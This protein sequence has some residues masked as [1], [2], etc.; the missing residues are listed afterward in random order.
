MKLGTSGFA[1]RHNPRAPLR[2]QAWGTLT[3]LLI[4]VLWMN[5][6]AFPQGSPDPLIALLAR[7]PHDEAVLERVVDWCTEQSS[8]ESFSQQLLQS[9]LPEFAQNR[10]L[11]HTVVGRLWDEAGRAGEA[12]REYEAAWAAGAR[13]PQT[14]LRMT[15]L[16]IDTGWGERAREIWANGS[17]D[18]SA[19]EVRIRFEIAILC[20]GPRAAGE[21]L[22]TQEELVPPAERARWAEAAA[23]YESA[24]RLF[25]RGGQVTAAVRCWARAG[26]LDQA[27]G[28]WG[29]STSPIDDDTALALARL[30]GDPSLLDA[31]LEERNDDA[32]LRLRQQ[33]NLAFGAAPRTDTEATPQPEV[34][35]PNPPELREPTATSTQSTPTQRESHARSVLSGNESDIAPLL[36]PG[37]P[38]L[39]VV[40][41]LLDVGRERLARLEWTRWQLAPHAPDKRTWLP[42]LRRRMPSWFPEVWSPEV[43]LRLAER[44]RVDALP[45]GLIKDLERALV[46]AT[47]GSALEAQLLFHRGRLTDFDADL[48]RALR[49]APHA[50]IGSSGELRWVVPL[51]EAVKRVRGEL[52][53]LWPGEIRIPDPIDAPLGVAFGRPLHLGS[54]PLGVTEHRTFRWYLESWEAPPPP[55]ELPAGTAWTSDRVELPHGKSWT[56]GALAPIHTIIHIPE[57]GWIVVGQGLALLSIE[58]PHERLR[59]ETRDSIRIRHLPPD[60]ARLLSPALRKYLECLRVARV[61]RWSEQQNFLHG[62]RRRQGDPTIQWTSALGVDDR[63]LL[64][65]SSGHRVWLS[66]NKP[67]ES[68]I[69]YPGYSMNSTPGVWSRTGSTPAQPVAPQPEPEI[70]ADNKLEKVWTR[71]VAPASEA[72]P[73]I[74]PLGPEEPNRRA[75]PEFLRPEVVVARVGDQPCVKVTSGGHVL[76]YP[77]DDELPRWISRIPAPLPGPQGFPATT[78]ASTRTGSQERGPHRAGPVGNARKPRIFVF[79]DTFLV[80]TDSVHEFTWDGVSRSATLPGDAVA[81]LDVA[82]NRAGYW[83]LTNNS[84]LYRIDEQFE[85]HTQDWRV[86][87]SFDLETLDDRLFALQYESG[88]FRL[89]EWAGGQAVQRVIPALLADE[90]RSGQRI[91]SL[92]SWGQHLVLLHEDLYL[93]DLSAAGPTIW[94]KVVEWPGHR[95]SRATYYLQSRPRTAGNTVIVARPWGV[96]EGWEV[97]QP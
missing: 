20:E 60:V 38:R 30:T 11:A 52:L 32:A 64:R 31:H 78:L 93:G 47:P 75:F 16:L 68:S 24:A 59:V 79:E 6:S 96:I 91:V 35:E 34:P 86:A 61:A 89:W 80:V 71:T 82:K 17:E 29:R 81:V 18:F 27:M 7:R 65:A 21:W 42:R 1:A 44:T 33:L 97:V 25:D 95:A 88:Q 57:T 41:A 13:D 84:D 83:A 3:A 92:G 22:E 87:R 45:E 73:W 14:R 69:R 36:E 62:L 10:G 37:P 49:I 43:P 23:V 40:A 58:A 28:A 12:F 77:E 46:E 48:G 8:L 2:R 67:S 51:E 55:P 76:F 94:T 39:A 74:E 72:Q 70:A 50:P 56:A 26:E 53:A 90:D 9:T 15:E 66:K 5:A 19:T 85:L 54:Y 63:L 4:S